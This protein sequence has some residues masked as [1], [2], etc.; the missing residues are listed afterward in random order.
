MMM[1]TREQ[2]NLFPQKMGVTDGKLDRL[3]QQKFLRSRRTGL[4]QTV[5]HLLEQYPLVRRV[6]I[7]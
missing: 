4:L 3:G 1:L 7:E 2:G 5:E 6:L